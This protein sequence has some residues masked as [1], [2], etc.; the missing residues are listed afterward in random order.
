MNAYAEFVKFMKSR[1]D[2]EFGLQEGYINSKD[3]K[4][5]VH[6]PKLRLNDCKGG[7]NAFKFV[8][9]MNLELVEH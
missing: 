9:K 3:S 2:V 5:L 7:M 6:G 8:V 1:G 4:T